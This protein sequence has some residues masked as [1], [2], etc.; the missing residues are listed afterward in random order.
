MTANTSII[1]TTSA[2]EHVVSRFSE[3]PF[4]AVDTEFMRE[5]TYYPQLCLIQLS[6][7]AEA[8]CVDPLAEGISLAPLFELMQNEN[9]VKVFH[10]G[11]Q[12]MEIFVHLSGEA[13]T[14]VYDT[15]IAAMVIGLGE[16]VGYDKLVQH[17][18]CVNL[19]KSSRFTNWAERPLSERQISY[20]LDDVIYLA[21]IYPKML[22]NLENSGRHDWVAADMNVFSKKE[23]YLVNPD[24]VWRKLKPRSQKPEFLN[25]LKYLC[26]WREQEAQRRNMPRGRILR[27]DTIMDLAGS[28]PQSEKQL[29]KIRGFPRN[30]NPAFK[31]ALVT[32]LQKAAQ[33][34]LPAP[35]Q[36]RHG[37]ER[38]PVA[39]MEL[40]KVLLKHVCE[41]ENVAPRLIATTDQIEALA[42]GQHDELGCLEGWRFEIFG[43]KALQLISGKLG[44]SIKDNKVLLSALD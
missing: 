28:N 8:C 3:R 39:T 40:L 31:N 29:D 20:A 27:D 38:P 2:L 12:D 26:A 6:D 25:R 23:N 16:Q 17:F 13:P 15:Q 24:E 1:T 41:S 22:K 4:I 19:D 21:E 32:Q 37:H 18:C 35:A 30:Q 33:T 44:L 10:A 7:G 34:T 36:K 5:T 9:V 11:K 42:L 43:N 14:P